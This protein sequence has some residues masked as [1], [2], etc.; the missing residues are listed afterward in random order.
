MLIRRLRLAPPSSTV[1]P[2]RDELRAA[3]VANNFLAD[4]PFKAVSVIV[5]YGDVEDLNASEFEVDHQ[6]QSLNVT[7]QLDG[8]A[9][10]LL[11][12]QEQANKHKLALIEVLC[13]V[14]A[15]FDLPFQFLDDMR[16]E[17]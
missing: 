14:A 4:A 6:N 8:R 12:V 7:I 17:I 1:L 10:A 2:A 11:P 9:L 5:R 16:H 15:N 13:D 3:M